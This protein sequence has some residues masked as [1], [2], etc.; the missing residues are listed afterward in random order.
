LFERVNPLVSD[1]YFVIIAAGAMA[2][3]Q[4]RQRGSWMGT[5]ADVSDVVFFPVSSLGKFLLKN[6]DLGK[7]PESG[8]GLRF[9]VRRA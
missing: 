5:N 4:P 1:F 3:H 7:P 2:S 8:S 9:N 6:G